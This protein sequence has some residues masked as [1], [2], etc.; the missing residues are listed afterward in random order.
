MV[1]GEYIV[2]YSSHSNFKEIELFVAS[3][4]PAVLKCVVRENRS[5]YQKLGNI[6]QQFNTY[7]F[8]LQSLKQTGYDLL[9]KKYADIKTASPEY[10]SL[11]NPLVIAEVSEKLGLKNNA[12][13]AMEED[14]RRFDASMSQILKAKNSRKLNKGIKIKDPELNDELT[15]EDLLFLKRAEEKKEKGLTSTLLPPGHADAYLADEDNSL[16]KSLKRVQLSSSTGLSTAEGSFAKDTQLSADADASMQAER[17]GSVLGA[18][19][20]RA[21]E[22]NRDFDDEFQ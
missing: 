20:S 6:K 8:T 21:H 12:T 1:E 16:D 4:R 10:L 9:I 22:E 19:G 15:Q 14:S 11:M 3:L 13:Q 17:R 18:A 7:M 5:N 2:P